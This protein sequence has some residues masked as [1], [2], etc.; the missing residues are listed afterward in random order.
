MATRLIVVVPPASPLSV[1]ST[2]ELEVRS[3]PGLTVTLV[4]PPLIVDRPA[5]SANRMRPFRREGDPRRRL[6]APR[7]ARRREAADPD[8]GRGFASDALPDRGLAPHPAGAAVLGGV[9]EHAGVGL[10]AN[11]QHAAVSHDA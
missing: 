4:F 8:P 11:E 9:A 1:A 2:N 10:R 3:I 5:T 6:E 7:D